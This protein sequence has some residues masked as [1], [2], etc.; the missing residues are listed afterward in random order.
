MT[1][2]RMQDYNSW[3]NIYAA[4]R[5]YNDY[6][7]PRPRARWFTDR[8]LED[9]ELF[10]SLVDIQDITS[11]EPFLLNGAARARKKQVTESIPSPYT[12]EITNR[13]LDMPLRM[14]Y[15]FFALGKPGPHGLPLPPLAS[16]QAW[17]RERTI[18]LLEYGQITN[19]REV[20]LLGQRRIQRI[21]GIG[22]AIAGQAVEFV[23]AIDSRLSVPHYTQPSVAALLYGSAGVVPARVLTDDA[24]Q[25]TRGMTVGDVLDMPLTKLTSTF[26]KHSRPIQEA[27]VTFED[28]FNQS[29]ERHARLALESLEY[30]QSLAPPPAAHPHPE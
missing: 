6:T 24:A 18:N 23:R 7:N 12:D 30:V 1:E 4:H 20:M 26:G 28:A 17:R 14:A 16:R 8:A 27:A 10:S 15:N 3:D 25:K 11:T 5:A 13:G 21:Q 29:E 19:F 2:K 9:F 22:A